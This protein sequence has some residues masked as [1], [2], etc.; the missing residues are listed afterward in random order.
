MYAE[1][2]GVRLPYYLDAV[3][4]LAEMT[5]AADE[6][7]CNVALRKGINMVEAAD[8]LTDALSCDISSVRSAAGEVLL[9][10]DSVLG[11]EAH[12]SVEGRLRHAVKSPNKLMRDAA[13]DYFDRLMN[14]RKKQNLLI[15]K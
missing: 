7:L 3:R 9:R 6:D 15:P 4:L 2:L 13:N 8:Y 14:Q 5:S 11:K 1:I 10:L 12:L